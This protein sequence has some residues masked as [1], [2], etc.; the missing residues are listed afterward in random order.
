MIK[1]KSCDTCKH[2]HLLSMMSPCNRC[3][4]K[5]LSEWEE[6]DKGCHNCSSRLRGRGNYP[7]S[8]C[9]ISYSLRWEPEKRVRAKERSH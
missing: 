4:T 6:A 3:Y 7:C 2:R 1:A 8:I 9:S 5:S